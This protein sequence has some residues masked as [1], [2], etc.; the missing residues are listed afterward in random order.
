MPT[1]ARKEFQMAS[2]TK[3][4]MALL[5]TICAAMVADANAP[6]YMATAKEV[7]NLVDNGLAETNT[8][9][10]DGDKFAVRA[11]EKG[12][13]ENDAAKQGTNEMP[14]TQA[15]A[16]TGFEV[17]KLDAPL[18][19]KRTRRA[20][21]TYP[22]ETMDVN[23]IFFVAAT[24]DKENPAKSMA[25]T[26]SSANKRFSSETG[27]TKTVTVKTYQLDA[28]GKR[29]KDANGKLIATGTETKTVPVLAPGKTF[30]VFPVEAGEELGGFT[31]PAKGVVVQRVK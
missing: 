31:A 20:S 1:L 17:I 23:S 6:F 30:E 19:K 15:T 21:A 16:P 13:A 12:V 8:D 11:T 2:V 25:S 10:A 9:I 4:D 3:K 7:K 27:E 18:T 14:E 5:A 28:N 24:A 29:A 26:V 22:F